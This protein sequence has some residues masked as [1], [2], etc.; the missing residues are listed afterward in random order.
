M[1]HTLISI[2]QKLKKIV[3]EKNS[4]ISLKNRKFE[5]FYK[6]KIL[7]AGIDRALGPGID[8]SKSVRD[9]QNFVSPGPLQV[10]KI[11]VSPS[12]SRSGIF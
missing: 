3:S 12:P 1:A 6:S 9:F 8:R 4:K 10:L 2:H 11:F 7:S 5:K